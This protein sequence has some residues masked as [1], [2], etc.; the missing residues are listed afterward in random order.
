MEILKENDKSLFWVVFVGFFL[1][2]LIS[3][4]GYIGN[5]LSLF[6]WLAVI[7]TLYLTIK[8][9]DYGLL[10]L[11][12]EFLAGHEGHL[13]SFA[14]LESCN[15]ISSSLPALAKIC[16]VSFLTGFAGISLRLA[17]FLVVMVVWFFSGRKAIKP[18]LIFSIFIF[19][20]FLSLIN[21]FSNSNPVFALKDFI[22]FSYIFLVFPLIDFLKNKQNQKDLFVISKA[23]VFALAILTIFVLIIF[24]TGLAQVHDIFYWWWRGTVIGK[25]TFAGNNFFR[26]VT[27]AHLLV[28]PLLLIYLSILLNHV[29]NNLPKGA[30]ALAEE[31][32]ATERAGRLDLMSG[33][34]RKAKFCPSE[35]PWR[36]LADPAAREAIA[37]EG[38]TKFGIRARF[39]AGESSA[40]GGKRFRACLAGAIL[41]AT[42]ALLINFSRAYL[43]GLFAGLLFL[44]FGL[45][46]KKWFKFTVVFLLIMFSELIII[47]T[48]V[49]GGKTFGLDFFAGRMKTTIAPEEELSS[50]T[51]LAILPVLLEK[52]KE[53]PILGH[54]L[55]MTVSYLDPLTKEIKITRHLDWGYLEMLVELGVF[56]F[57]SFL[58]LIFSLFYKIFKYFREF[59]LNGQRIVIGLGAGLVALLVAA[60]T[61]PFLFHALG[62]F[63]LSLVIAYLYSPT[64]SV[65][66]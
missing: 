30:G 38:G 46:F 31:T 65:T 1:F 32:S 60:A 24:S 22:N 52:I 19:F 28:L 9:I 59:D 37:A 27:P 3:F 21:G 58:V 44:S 8:K 13:F 66:K 29:G 7:V 18:S 35:A 5:F 25:V 12:F 36:S 45:P 39:H 50:A 41:L 57:L 23:L 34:A 55:G 6:F 40:F 63:Y 53:K 17:L 64:T 4:L 33:R 42:S 43:L 61:G 51:R 62:I 48:S 10:I 20:L 26:I 47:F 49:S 2:Q 16:Q 15:W 11:F 56:G 54:G 14:P